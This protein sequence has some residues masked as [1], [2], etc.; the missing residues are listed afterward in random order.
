MPDVICKLCLQ[1]KTLVESHLIP[2]AVYELL[3]APDAPNPNP[4]MVTSKL[5]MQTSRQLK[6]YLLCGDCEQLLNRQGEFRV[7]PQLATFDGQFA[8]LDT[9]EKIEPEFREPDLLG[10]AAVRNADIRVG[11]LI[12]FALGIFWK[13]SVHRFE[14]GVTQGPRIDLG[15]YQEKLRAYLRGGALPEGTALMV[16]FAP[17]PV[18][19]ISTHAPFEAKR[20]GAPCRHF[21]F[22]VPGIAFSLCTGKVIPEEILYCCLYT[23]PGN[24][25]FVG[26]TSPSATGFLKQA[27]A[28]AHKSRKLAEWFKQGSPRKK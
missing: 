21:N 20:S 11:S 25:I 27:F 22:Y 14:G 1:S 26:D 7:L 5:A 2:R 28:T 9:L 12:H 19:L 23:N 13:A 17:K 16:T 6:T 15:P 18:S 4:I 10:Y 24:P 3:Q 8:L